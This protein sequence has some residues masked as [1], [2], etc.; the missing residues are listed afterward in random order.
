M[1]KK[2]LTS[3][4]LNRKLISNLKSPI[5]VVGGGRTVHNCSDLLTCP[6]GGCVDSY[7]C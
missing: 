5:E 6:L 7:N 1:K 2:N 4:V 3:L